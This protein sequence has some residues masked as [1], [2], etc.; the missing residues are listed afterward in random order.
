MK[1]L[2]PAEQFTMRALRS[3]GVAYVAVET[4]TTGYSNLSKYQRKKRE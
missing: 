4:G 2:K 3:L 1:F